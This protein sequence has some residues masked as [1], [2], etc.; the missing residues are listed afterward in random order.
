MARNGH[1]TRSPPARPPPARLLGSLQGK[2]A[3]E[4]PAV[5]PKPEPFGRTLLLAWPKNGEQPVQ[6]FVPRPKDGWINLFDHK[7]AL[8]AI[9]IPPNVKMEHY[10]RRTRGKKGGVWAPLAWKAYTNIGLREVFVLRRKGK[11]GLRIVEQCSQGPPSARTSHH[12]RRPHRALE[13]NPVV[14]SRSPRPSRLA[15]IDLNGTEWGI[16]LKQHPPLLFKVSAAHGPK[17]RRVGAR[18]TKVQILDLSSRHTSATV[19]PSHPSAKPDFHVGLYPELIAC[20]VLPFFSFY[21]ALTACRAGVLFLVSVHVILRPGPSQKPGAASPGALQVA[22]PVWQIL[23]PEHWGSIPRSSTGG[24][25]RYVSLT[26]TQTAPN[27]GY[28]ES[29]K[30]RLGVLEQHAPLLS[31]WPRP[32]CLPLI[33]PNGASMTKLANFRSPCNYPSALA[34]RS[35]YTQSAGWDKA[36]AEVKARAEVKAQAA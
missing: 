9:G 34:E 1:S 21:P 15:L 25:A 35:S 36:Q 26:S 3:R 20:P 4:L 2:D 14:L 33:D 29:P 12:T 17:Q 31:R 6:I 30:L 23:D 13:Q 27:G 18:M 24:P 32:S 16:T 22:A 7:E 11:V 10:S 28:D 19:K 8:E 5:R